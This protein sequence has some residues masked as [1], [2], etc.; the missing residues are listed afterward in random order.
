MTTGDAKELANWYRT[1]V[2]AVNRAVSCL[3]ELGS[4]WK[5][6]RREVL[7]KIR[8]LPACAPESVPMPALFAWLHRCLGEARTL[9]RGLLEIKK[10]AGRPEYHKVRSQLKEAGHS[11][12]A[13]SGI[14]EVLLIGRCLERSRPGHVQVYPE[15]N[16]PSG[17]R[18][19]LAITVGRKTVYVEITLLTERPADEGV[20]Q[21]NT[22]VEQDGGR[23]LFKLLDKVVEDLDPDRSQLSARHPNVIILCHGDA[24][25]TYDEAFN[26]AFRAVGCDPARLRN[27]VLSRARHRKPALAPKRENAIVACFSSISAILAFADVRGARFE[28]WTCWRTWRSSGAGFPLEERDV[29]HIRKLFCERSGGEDSAQ[30]GSQGGGRDRGALCPGRGTTPV[31]REQEE[32]A[33]DVSRGV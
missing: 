6:I 26:W 16:P 17:K 5:G 23:I 12:Q 2:K 11:R 14:V 7:A 18:A 31:R 25:E 20:A 32:N 27:V 15:V 13:S 4:L 10:K 21:K 24:W 19:D 1:K 28:G 22:S 30:V 9:E 8:N 33:E 3:G 29:Q